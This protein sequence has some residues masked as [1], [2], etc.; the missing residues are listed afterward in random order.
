MAPLE[1]ILRL[2][3]AAIAGYCVGS[4]PSGVVVGRLFGNVDP[5]TRGSGKTGTTN[6]L[7][8]LGP[9]P[10]ALVLILDLAKGVAAVLLARY[11]LM[12]TSAGASLDLRAWAEA[13]A[14]LAA[15]LGHTFSIFIHFTG[16]RGVATG[17]GAILAMQPVVLAV[18]VVAIVVP[19]A[20]TRYVSLGSMLAA[21]ACAALD[22]G[23]VLSGHDVWGHAA[24]M[25][26]GAFFILWSHRDN[27]ER[28]VH[29]T[30][31]KLGQPREVEA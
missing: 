9:G 22:L 12:P 6:I 11:L 17:A 30:E 13:V 28:L 10:A 24:F 1:A 23:L 7:R 27:I 18:G 8:T 2:I 26:I 5:R 3:A 31:R 29:G 15:V 14:A 19:I 4:I 25:V 16:G 20:I 21:I